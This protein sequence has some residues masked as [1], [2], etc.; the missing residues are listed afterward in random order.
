M[1]V[2]L[3][4]LSYG[5]EMKRHCFKI[6]LLMELCFSAAAQNAPARINLV[7]VEGEGVSTGIRQRVAH[8]PVVLVEDDDHRP[9]PGAAVVF[10]LPV[11]GASGEF[12][13]GA[14]NYTV[15]TGS[16]GHAT[17]PGLKTNDVPGK[18]QIYVTASYRGLRA[19][20]LIN[21]TVEAAAGAKPRS[22]EVRSSKSGNTWKWVLLGV[23]A[24]GGAGA[25][26]Y[27][28]HHSSST[29][30]PSPISIST[31]TVVFGSPR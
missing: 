12:V 1:P 25:G 24:A 3:T 2:R 8:D 17:A 19:R 26:I 10:A 14:K 20:S 5:L 27:L 28:Q 4:C 22:P 23:A 15:V 31:G 6:L 13:N 7:V 30:A 21:E 11:S 16:D 9:V 29:A 18:L